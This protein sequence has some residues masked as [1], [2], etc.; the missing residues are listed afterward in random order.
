MSGD[1]EVLEA[2]SVKSE[3]KAEMSKRQMQRLY[4]KLHTQRSKKYALKET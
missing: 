1:V 4:Y 2:P 3:L